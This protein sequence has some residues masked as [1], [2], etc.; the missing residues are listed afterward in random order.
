MSPEKKS[1]LSES[2]GNFAIRIESSFESAHFLYN[3]FPDGSDEPMHGH[4]WKAVV[5]L[6]QIGGGAG[7]DGICYDFIPAGNKLKELT[8][9]LDHT[10][11]NHISDFAGI[12]PT[13]ENIAR[14]LYAGLKTAVSENSG[15][16]HKIEVFE[17]PVNAAVFIPNDR[18]LSL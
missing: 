3:Y 9:I 8:G 1:F 12:N 7:E 11:I 18:T 13:A 2:E 16:V 17:G 10:V 15:M 4:S 6:G 14:W 5:Y